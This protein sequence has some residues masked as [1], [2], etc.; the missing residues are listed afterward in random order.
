MNDDVFNKLVLQLNIG[1]GSYPALTGHHFS[2]EQYDKVCTILQ[3]RKE[4]IDRY[5]NTTVKCRLIKR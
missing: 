1:C 3:K 5:I 2:K 4:T